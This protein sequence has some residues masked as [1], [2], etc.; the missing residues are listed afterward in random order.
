MQSQPLLSI[1][2]NCKNAERTISRHIKAVISAFQCYDNIEY[3]VQDGASKDKTLQIFEDYKCFFGDRLR[4]ISE[5]D[6]S[7]SEGFW[8]GIARCR[9]DI[10]CTSM[11]DEEILPDAI[12]AAVDFFLANPN[13]D[14]LHG[15]IYQT[16]LEGNIQF[17]NKSTK[18]DLTA[19]LSHQLPMHF[20][21]S[22]FRRSVF[23]KA[24]LLPLPNVYGFLEDD[25]FIWC[26][27]GLHAKI[28]Y[29]PQVFAKYAVH[30]EALSVRSDNI[31]HIIGLRERFFEN[32]FK[33]SALPP[34]LRAK[35]IECLVNFYRWGVNSLLEAGYEERAKRY[36]LKIALLQQEV[37]DLVTSG[38]HLKVLLVSLPGL[39]TGDEPIFPLGIGYLLAS[40][41]QDKRPVQA[42]HYQRP[43]HVYSQLPEVMQRFSPDIVGLT[44]TTFNRGLVREICTWLRTTHPHVRIVLGGVHVSFMYEQALR[45]YGADYVVIGEGEITLRELCTALDQN[46]PLQEINGIAF[47]HDNQLV[48][49]HPRETVQ[50]LDE[51]PMPDYSFAGELM[52]RS[53]MGFVISS[54]GCP[55]QCS[56]CSTS[57]YWGQKV[58]MNSPR[59]VVDEM[60]SLVASY[61]VKKI[62]FH[63]DTFNLGITRVR[64]ICAE[65]TG[66]GLKVE[67]GASCRVSPV[68]EEM[69]DLMVAAG[70]RHIC[71]GIESGSK[72]MLARIGKR[73]TQEQI[74][75]AFECCR[76]H[77][78][79]ISVG[80]FTMVGNPGESPKTIAESIQFIGSLQMTDPPSTAVLY[81]LPG[82]KLY[83]ELLGTCPELASYWTA[84]DAV[85][86]YTLEYPMETLSEWSRQI[87]LSASLVPFD[88]NKH[89][90]N[91]V[92]FGAIPEP[93]PPSLSFLASELD[94]VIP[95]EIKD[96]E[97]YH[98]IQK[99]AEE[100]AVR[101]VLEIGS[102]AGGGSTEA[103]VKGLGRN[104]N[105]PRLFCMEVSKP[106]FDALRERYAEQTFVRCYHVSSIPIA[107]F[108]SEETVTE[109]YRTTRTGL[110]NYPLERVIGWLYQDID[111]ILAAGVPQDGIERIKRENQI[112]TFDMVL[113]DGSEFTGEAELEQV[114]GAKLILLDD[115]NGFKNYRNRQRLFADPT[116]SLVCE[117]WGVRNG[118]AVFRKNPVSDL[119][120]HF[121]T[122]VLNGEP[123]IKQHLK[124]F[125]KLPFR[126][127]WHIVEGVAELKHDT[128]W[129]LQLGGRI[130]GELHS[131]GLSNDGTT[132]Y[133]DQLA[134]DHPDKISVYRKPNGQF[135]DG[136]L[137]MVSAPFANITEECLLWQV[138]ADEC[139][140]AAQITRARELFDRHPEKT[141]AF[142]YCNFHVG[143]EL[144]II[145]RNTYG[146]NT[147]YEWLR[148]WRYRP[149]DV[150]FSHEPPQLCRRDAEGAWRNLAENAFTHGETEAVGLV[151]EHYAYATEGQLAFK[152][153]YYGY[154]DAVERWQRLQTAKAMPVF[155]RDYFPW[156]HDEAMVGRRTDGSR[157]EG[158]RY[159]IWLRSDAIGDNVLASSMLPYVKEAY[160]DA[161]LV[162]VCQDR[163][164]PLYDACP[165]VDEVIAY[166]LQLLSNENYRNIITQQ[167]NAYK[168]DILLNT[169]YSRDFQSYYLSG[170]SNAQ[171]KIACEGDDCNFPPELKSD[172]DRN[173]TQIIPNNQNCK[174]ELDKH[175]HFLQAIGI[176]TPV[177]SPQVWL[178]KKD[179]ALAEKLYSQ[180]D[181]LPERTLVV[182]P[183]ALFEQ[184]K[185]Q[186]F[187]RVLQGLHGYTLLLMGGDDVKQR[188]EE[189]CA[190]YPGR[191]F[192]LAGKTTI[193]QMAAIIGKARLYIG[194]DTSGAHVACAVGLPNVVILGGGH[195]GRFLP[196]SELTTA[197]CF[198]LECYNCRWKCRFSRCHCVDDIRPDAVISAVKYALSKK[199]QLPSLYVQAQSFHS[200]SPPPLQ[201]D[202]LAEMLDLD[203]IEIIEG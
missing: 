52:R 26:Y 36:S 117:N 188:C 59:R 34:E 132:E 147:S 3:V 190:G 146:N 16:D 169:V 35:R 158:A 87:S 71:W 15:D 56:F 118:Y 88:R 143:P 4:L 65:I 115:I 196:Y 41:R 195:F 176:E 23:E 90:W 42:L 173:F 55:V 200:D 179:I 142:Y 64:E 172:N 167:V 66:R 160:H 157:M 61:G 13:I 47:L 48:T 75:K 27:L 114:Y 182:F 96:D 86:Y 197:V 31:E 191:A 5:P 174:A 130:S 125:L 181:L 67:W 83:A 50:N 8:R 129:S 70:C 32:Y 12:P 54:L 185:Y 201:R 186:H 21:A 100:E 62:F 76:K 135:W 198:L 183:G 85:P 144:V 155:L 128:A 119:P 11:A 127:H 154:R 126:W 141:A 136:K 1:F 7:A 145:T 22:F 94:Q 113:I 57:S 19:Y 178:A 187:K 104:G 152:E 120:I 79:V 194:L 81:I 2:C 97:F 68:S 14:V 111:Y 24:G 28:V 139:W 10:I 39:N 202:R 93:T 165:Y 156:V 149:G 51:L 91:K 192:N 112:T 177:L 150:W 37:D 77:L 33:D 63:D 44:C 131:N 199:K 138:D 151:F 109:F 60:E 18:F 161:R 134:Q 162:M 122:I 105:H 175:R 46:L 124:Q 58:R 74:S 140:T 20:A 73:I 95:P 25:F 164:A 159:I 84:Y 102:S 99:L 89:F 9:G 82:T 17:I 72:A 92:L 40:L 43:D 189:L 137:E 184:K 49:T 6:S 163:V 110:N 98:V 171:H 170:I 78:G 45:E 116:Y 29:V 123:F 69:I 38:R 101:T 53:G 166:N 80:A 180:L 107:Q 106:R 148:T 121:F 108:P 103:F 203:A 30:D 193:L 168:P 153:I 133:L